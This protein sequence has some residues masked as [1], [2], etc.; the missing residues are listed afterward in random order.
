LSGVTGAA[1][2]GLTLVPALLINAGGALAGAGIK[3]ENPNGS[4]AGAA[5]GTV[6]GYSI[7]TR[8]EGVLGN[9]FNPWY[10][11]EWKEIGMGISSFVPK[12]PIPSW[13]GG[14]VG[15]G[16]QELLGG[17]TQKVLEKER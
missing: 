1:S 16:T 12:S 10:R 14:V 15:G 3:S 2:S 6:I 11:S 7:G 17:T 13:A 5:V 4:M 8:T 9:V